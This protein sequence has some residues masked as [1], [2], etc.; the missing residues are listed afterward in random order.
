MVERADRLRPL[1][2]HPEFLAR[3]LA[4]EA[5]PP[6][7]P[8]NPP[9]PKIEWDESTPPRAVAARCLLSI[10]E[11]GV[12]AAPG[13]VVGL[14]MD[15]AR[16]LEVG[17]EIHTRSGRRYEIASVRRQERGK[18]IGRWHLRCLVLAPDHP[19][20]PDVAVHSIWW[21]PR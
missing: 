14:Y 12:K 11:S 13:A 4:R 20:D 3:E 17:D 5:S 10:R 8:P 18:H 7:G 19:T 2:R 9:R 6:P 16:E 1:R 21:Y 15:T